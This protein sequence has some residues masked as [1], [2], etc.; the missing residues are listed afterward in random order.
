MGLIPSQDTLSE[1]RHV[2]SALGLLV[3]LHERAQILQSCGE[4]AT[5]FTTLLLH[6]E[7]ERIQSLREGEAAAEE[8]FFRSTGREMKDSAQD[9]TKAQAWLRLMENFGAGAL[10]MANAA[11]NST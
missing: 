2:S 6:H 10:L 11:S 8:M 9:R 3:S 1:S 5:R 7:Y 4:I